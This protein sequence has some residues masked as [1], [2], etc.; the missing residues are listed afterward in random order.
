MCYATRMSDNFWAGLILFVVLSVATGIGNWRRERHWRRW[1]EEDR[2]TLEKRAAK[3]ARWRFRRD[4]FLRRQWAKL[5]GR[6]RT[7]LIDA[8]NQ[9]GW[10]GEGAGVRRIPVEAVEVVSD[11]RG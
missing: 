5:R 6:S 1:A 10:Q 9:D 2:I 7:Q 11:R 4:A 8:G 3:E